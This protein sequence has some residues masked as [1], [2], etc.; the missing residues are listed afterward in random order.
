MRNVLILGEDGG[1]GQCLTLGTNTLI[2]GRIFT[3]A[4]QSPRKSTA[5]IPTH[6]KPANVVHR[7]ASSASPGSLQEIQILKLCL[8]PL[9]QNMLTGLSDLYLY[10]PERHCFRERAISYGSCEDLMR[11]HVQST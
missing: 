1:K 10:A 2:V 9:N 7:H 6:A 11:K 5:T 3:S 4:F 8:K